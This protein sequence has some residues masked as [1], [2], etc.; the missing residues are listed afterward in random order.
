MQLLQALLAHQ[1]SLGNGPR[2]CGCDELLAQQPAQPCMMHNLQAVIGHHARHMRD[3]G[4]RAVHDKLAHLLMLLAPIAAKQR[5]QQGGRQSPMLETP[6]HVA[7]QL[8]VDIRWAKKCAAEMMGAP[9]R[10]PL[11]ACACRCCRSLCNS[12]RTHLEICAPAMRHPCSSMRGALLH[13]RYLSRGWPDVE[14]KSA[15]RAL[16]GV[17]CGAEETPEARSCTMCEA[18]SQNPEAMQAELLR[19]NTAMEVAVMEFTVVQHM[20]ATL[21]P[22]LYYNT[23][24]TLTSLLHMPAADVRSL[25]HP[26]APPPPPLAV[27]RA[28]LCPRHVRKI[29]DRTSHARATCIVQG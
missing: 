14:I 15:L 23:A 12:S 25:T 7:S 5:T 24:A 13:C 11:C 28:L 19:L 6:V 10:H 1:A 29:L 21:N 4:L 20:T 26:L 16:T 27:D 9:L 18:L 8:M 22:Q 3:D 17:R 2:D